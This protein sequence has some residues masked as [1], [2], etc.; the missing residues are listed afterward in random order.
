MVAEV[1]VLPPQP[2]SPVSTCACCQ[3]AE[4]PAVPGHPRDLVQSLRLGSAPKGGVLAACLRGPILV[5]R[6]WAELKPGSHDLSA[7]TAGFAGGLDYR[8]APDTVVGLAL[9]GGGTAGVSRASSDQ[10][11]AN[12]WPQPIV[13]IRWLA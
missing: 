5:S 11:F 6:F 10:R 13:N 3:S 8:L 12:D 1:R 2:A 9:A 4:I 7:R